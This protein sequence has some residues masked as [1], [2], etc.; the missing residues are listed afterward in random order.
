MKAFHVLKAATVIVV[1]AQIAGV[2]AMKNNPPPPSNSEPAHG[3]VGDWMK[4]LGA[5]QHDTANGY[6]H[7]GGG[8]IAPWQAVFFYKQYSQSLAKERL[9]GQIALA[10]QLNGER[11]CG[12]AVCILLGDKLGELKAELSALE[13]KGRMEGGDE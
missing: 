13:Q 9:E 11:R 1:G 10:E 3:Q 2:S 7:V 8:F 6:W 12:C 4:S 5:T